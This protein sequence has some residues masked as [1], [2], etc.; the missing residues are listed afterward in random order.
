MLGINWKI[1]LKVISAIAFI[2]GVAFLIPFFIS[3]VCVESLNLS[4]GLSSGII[5]L[6]SSFLYFRTR[7]ASD[8]LGKREGYLIV[9]L[10]WFFIGI[11]G[12]LPYYFSIDNLS[13]ASSIFESFSGLTTTGATIFNDLEIL[14]R[15][16]L[17]WRSLTQW[18]GGMGIIVFTVAI[19]PLLGIGG[20]EL[21]VAESPG[22]T[23][24]KIHPRIRETARRL[25]YIYVSMTLML[26]VILFAEGM[27][28]F[29]SVN[30]GLTTMATGGFS[31]R[32]QSIAFYDSALIE[33]T[34][35][36][37]M[38]LSGTNFTLIYFGFKGKFQRFIQS[39]EFKAYFVLILLSTLFAWAVVHFNTVQPL[40]LSFRQS[41]FQVVSIITTTGFVTADYTSWQIAGTFFFF[42]LLF[43]GGCAGSTSGGV[44]IIRHLVFAKNSFLEFKRLLHQNALIRIRLDNEIV[45]ARIL[46]HILV[47]LLQYIFV[48]FA[49]SFIMT[50]ILSDFDQ[51]LLSALGAVA[52][53]LANVGPGIADLGP[54]DNFAAVPDSGKC[55]LSFIMLVGRLEIFSVLILFTPYF[56]R[57]N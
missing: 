41:L 57:N 17:M 52:T 38:F 49:G 55:V 25:W 34:L 26:M 9:T 56:W 45:R 29:D 14:P 1:I 27:D 3:I 8:K 35:V 48:F 13:F 22:P 12:S 33:Y 2:I 46:T 40:E 6:I 42:M 53:S 4:F 24:S 51:P 39:E 54:M 47:F 31:T 15:S 50:F 18:I 37:F 21:F 10:S 5:M 30:H 23:S 16:I 7:D 43:A 36:L 44:K 32:N 28:W 19:F 20:V 11:L